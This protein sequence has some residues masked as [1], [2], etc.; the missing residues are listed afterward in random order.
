[1][2]YLCCSLAVLKLAWAGDLGARGKS[3]G[4]LSTVAILGAIYSIWTI[5]GAG[6][7]AIYWG[8]GLLVAGVPVYVAMKKR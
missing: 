1:M 7:E 6:A 2:T 4:V 3:L 8:I 5:F